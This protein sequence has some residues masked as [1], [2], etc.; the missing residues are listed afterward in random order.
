MFVAKNQIF[1]VIACI[2]IGG[3]GGVLFSVSKFI[4]LFIKHARLKILPNIAAFCAFTAWYV[5]VSYRL[6]FPSYRVYMTAGALFGV[7]LYMKS[8]Y[9]TLALWTEKLYNKIVANIVAHKVKQKASGIKNA[10]RNERRKH[11]KKRGISAR[12]KFGGNRYGREF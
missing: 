10:K 7:L 12:R 8:F 2:A 3:I 11:Y 6:Q 4:K 1:V 5:W 9:I